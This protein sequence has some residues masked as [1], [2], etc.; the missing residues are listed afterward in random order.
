MKLF[1]CTK[2]VPDTA[3]TIKL[4]DETHSDDTVNFV[5]SP[6]DECALE[7]APQLRDQIGESS[8]LVPELGRSL[9]A[10]AAPEA[11]A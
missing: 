10:T 8:E 7:Q 6:H 3:A 2:H 4:T 5:I 11:R 9:S 1:V